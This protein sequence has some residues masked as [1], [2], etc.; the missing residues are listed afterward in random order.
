MDQNEYLTI[1]E[2]AEIAGVSKQAVYQRL[3]GTLKPYV[4]IRNGV[5]YV[6]IKALELYRED[7]TVKNLKK[8]NQV[9]SNN[10]QVDSM[11]E[12]LK[13]EL[14]AK[15]RQIDKLHMLLEQ[16]NANL[17]QAQY[18]LQ[19]IEESQNQESEDKEP[20]EVAVV[21]D[22]DEEHEPE[23]KKSWWRRLFDW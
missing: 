19:L 16:S 23:P 22:R 9:K 15:N 4:S 12:L 11:I 21:A 2:F 5:K 8:N 17:A 3:T 14:E 13:N 1:K 6:N 10:G 7:D 18:K 20:E